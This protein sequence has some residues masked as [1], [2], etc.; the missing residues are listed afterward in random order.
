MIEFYPQVKTLHMAMAIASGTLFALRGAFA[1][2]GHR[3]PHA[4]AVRVASWTIDT[5]LLTAALMLFSMLPSEA[6]A[7]GWLATKVALLVVYVGLGTLAMRT[8]SSRSMRVA[9]FAAALA[10]FG[11]IYSIARAHHPLGALAAAVA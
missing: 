1:I 8:S 11:S 3:W 10:A 4:L 2:A 5:T 6:F 9:G 7:N